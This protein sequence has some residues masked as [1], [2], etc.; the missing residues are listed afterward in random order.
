MAVDDVLTAASTMT[1]SPSHLGAGKILITP[2]TRLTV[3]GQGVLTMQAAGRATIAGCLQPAQPGPP[4]T[5]P[6]TLV[7][8]V[9]GASHRLSVDG[10]PVLLASAFTARTNSSPIAAVPLPIIPPPVPPPDLP[11]VEI[12][13]TAAQTLLRAE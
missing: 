7:S 3:R 12:T 2:A 8:G 13:V 1:C 11:P 6:C 10:S 4:L 9:G 5:K